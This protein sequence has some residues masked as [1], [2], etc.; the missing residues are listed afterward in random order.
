QR[1]ALAELSQKHRLP[2]M[3]GPKEYVEAGGL[4]GY[5]SDVEDT[6]RRAATY[7]D[8]ILRG[9]RPADLPVEQASKYELIV[10]LR[11]AKTLRITIPPLGPQGGGRIFCWGLGSGPEP[12]SCQPLPAVANVST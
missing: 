1:T 8:R 9:T 12:R 11:T 3:F 5:F 2:G 10:N 7:I 4:M 6:T